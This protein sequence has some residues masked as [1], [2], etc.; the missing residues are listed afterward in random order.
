M[1]SN[2]TYRLNARTQ[3]GGS[4]FSITWLTALI[5]FVVGS[6]LIGAASTAGV[7]IAGAVVTGPVLAGEYYYL[8][9]LAR[10]NEEVKFMDMFSGFTTNL[11]NNILISIITGIFTF[12]WSLLFVIPGIVKTYSYSMAYYISMD[13]PQKNWNECIT[14]SRKMMNG[15]KLK[16]FML[17][18]SF[19]G[20]YFLGA[21]I[22]GIGTLWVVPYHAS[23]RANFY[24][25]LKN[26]ISAN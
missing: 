13:N 4:I 22:F 19:I 1:K 18:L 10:G 8:L 12:L 26:N 5:V 6:A 24:E 2:S 21:L 15:Y 3:L 9:K 7:V 17:D 20:W 16:L 11:V 23:A 14:E 25:D